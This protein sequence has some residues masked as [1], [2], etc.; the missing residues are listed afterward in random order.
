MFPE[1]ISPPL[2]EEAAQRA[3]LARGDQKTEA[4]THYEAE[5]AGRSAVPAGLLSSLT[6]IQLTNIA[7]KRNIVLKKSWSKPEILNVLDPPS[8]ADDPM[9]VDP[10]EE[11]DSD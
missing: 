4:K 8:D 7:S 3:K 5:L 2:E 6:V 11:P 9:Q 10:S 1:L